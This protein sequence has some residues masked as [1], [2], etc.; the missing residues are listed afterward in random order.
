MVLGI[1]FLYANLFK[2]PIVEFLPYLAIG[3]V[4]WGAITSIVV[5][6]CDSLIQASGM[7]RQTAI[8]IFTF[9]WRSIFRNGITLAHHLVIVV[10]VLLWAGK[11]GE[12]RFV[13]MLGGIALLVANVSWMSLLAGIVSARFRDV[14]QIVTSVMQF[15]MFLTP[16]FWQSSQLS[17]K[18][19]ALMINPFYYMLDMVRQPLLGKP[20]PEHGA[21][22]LAALA[23]AGWVVAI[24]IFA[25]TR[26][27]IV[28][29]L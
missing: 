24:F 14:P 8:P 18:H 9:T 21:L 3:L 1:G 10:A 19:V 23:A 25:R 4:V 2:I 20:Q 16:V 27:R 13:P 15:A 28:H 12:A 29:Y 26:R 5:E 6:G 11:L 17:E 7:L 22:I